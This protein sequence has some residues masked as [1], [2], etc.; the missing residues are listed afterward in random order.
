MGKRR[1]SVVAVLSQDEEKEPGI[2]TGIDIAWI[3][4]IFDGEGCIFFHTNNSVALSVSMSDE[5]VIRRFHEIV[6][7]GTVRIEPINNNRTKHQYKW[8]ASKKRDVARLLCAMAPL[9]SNRRRE[10][11]FEAAERLSN[12]SYLYGEARCGT[13]SGYA[14]HRRRGEKPCDSCSESHSEYGKAYR[15]S[16]KDS[17]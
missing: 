15:Q 14:A 9:L 10:K 7:C 1:S 13:A 3:T 6:Q 17:K 5:D 12:I 16:K 4:G 2:M 8:Q 11:A